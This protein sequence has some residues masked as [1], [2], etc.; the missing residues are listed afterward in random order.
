MIRHEIRRLL[1]NWAELASALLTGLLFFWMVFWGGWFFAGLGL[2]GIVVA[3]IWSVGAFRRRGF[4]RDVAAPG[5][6]EIDEGAVRYYGARLL[7]GQLALRNLTE[8][9]LLRLDNHLHWRLKSDDG[10]A[11]LIPLEAAG[12]ETLADGFAALPGMDMGQVSAALARSARPDGPPFT[13]VWLRR[14]N[15]G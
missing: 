11:L 3:A 12:A 5:M 14:T 2:A 9:R 4:R 1:R 13:T 6:V 8:V 7:G 15:A 10:Q